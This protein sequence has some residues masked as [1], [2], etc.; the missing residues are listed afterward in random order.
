[1][2]QKE[3]MFFFAC[4]WVI[5]ESY[6]YVGATFCNP[7]ILYAARFFPGT[8]VGLFSGIGPLCN[9]ELAAP[10]MRGL[11]VSFYHLGI[12]IS[13]WLVYDSNFIDGTGAVNFGI[14]RLLL[15]LWYLVNVILVS[16]GVQAW[17]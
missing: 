13:F 17:L 7:S 11:V 3:Y 9:A 6:L 2:L 12:M 16:L 1:M 15:D 10:G 14:A 8:G 4:C 5:L